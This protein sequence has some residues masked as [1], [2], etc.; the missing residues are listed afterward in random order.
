MKLGKVSSARSTLAFLVSCTVVLPGVA[1]GGGG[2]AKGPTQAIVDGATPPR[3]AGPVDLSPVPEPEGTFVVA[4]LERPAKV[5]ETAGAWGKLP[6]PSASELVTVVAGSEAGAVVDLEQ[7]AFAAV[8]LEGRGLR[9]GKPRAAVA[10]A[11]RSYDDARAAF[12]KRFK[13][14]ELGAGLAVVEGLG[15]PP[16]PPSGGA[17]ADDD[18]DG[19]SPSNEACAI[20]P[21]AGATNGRL[22]CGDRGGLAKIA[23]YLTR[24]MPRGEKGADLHVEVR[25]AALRDTLESLKGLAPLVLGSAAAGGST[26]RL[27]EAAFG[28][29]FDV[30]GDMDRLVLDAN[31]GDAEATVTLRSSFQRTQSLV[32]KIAL[33]GTS[34][35]GAPPEAFARLPEDASVAWYAG[36]TD[37]ALLAHAKQLAGDALEEVMAKEGLPDADRRALVDLATD[38]L[39]ALFTRGMVYGKGEDPK[40]LARALERGKGAPAD[41]RRALREAAFGWHLVQVGEPVAK[42]GTTLKDLAALVGRLERRS[43]DARSPSSFELKNAPL[44]AGIPAESVHLVAVVRDTPSAPPPAPAKTAPKGGKAPAPAPAA[45]AGPPLEIHLLAVPDRGT[46][47]LAYGFDTKLLTERVRG[48]LAP[49]AKAKTLATRAGLEPLRRGASKAGGFVSLRGIGLL[50]ASLDGAPRA[51]RPFAQSPDRGT[52]PLVVLGARDPA[53]QRGPAPASGAYVTTVV[54][55]RTFVE[56]VVR[57]GMGN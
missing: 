11:L 57:A 48:V 4:R 3:T 12:G 6:V 46:T 9:G 1:C 5:L 30:A 28:E 40:A 25:L 24:T 34:V 27:L 51:A 14:T 16:A 41:E 42:T 36:P 50:A 8:T 35:E 37:P 33:D 19:P 52:A 23:P 2:G 20:A 49:D 18:D 7:P 56:D 43:R 53:G 13:L 21:S 39:P 44:P 10:I 38:R 15:Q 17:G 45:K 54:V 29:V 47:W 26:S 31:V 22:V 55:P 32:A